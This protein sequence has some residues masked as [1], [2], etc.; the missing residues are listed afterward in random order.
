[1]NLYHFFLLRV[2]DLSLWA[3]GVLL[4]QMFYRE[5]FVLCSQRFGNL[6]PFSSVISHSL[7]I[8]FREKERYDTQP[9]FLTNLR[10]IMEKM[11]ILLQVK[12]GH[13]I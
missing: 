4:R 2:C 12:T 13:F 3:A 6:R 7:G 9:S 11:F 10:D 5:L 8:S 1:M